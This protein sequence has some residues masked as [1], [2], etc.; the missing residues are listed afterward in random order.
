MDTMEAR[1]VPL[2]VFQLQVEVAWSPMMRVLEVL[3][4]VLGTFLR[5]NLTL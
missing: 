5:L 1:K 3:L 4:E 2:E